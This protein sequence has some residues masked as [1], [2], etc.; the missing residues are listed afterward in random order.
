[1]A[2]IIPE[3]LAKGCF[4]APEIFKTMMDEYHEVKSPMNMQLRLL[5]RGLAYPKKG[6][7]YDINL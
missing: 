4:V 3:V 2:E 6:R 5:K 1:M 7:D